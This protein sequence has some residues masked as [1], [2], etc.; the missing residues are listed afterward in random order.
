M[1]S[2]MMN[3]IV[4]WSASKKCFFQF[5]NR[6]FSSIWIELIDAKSKDLSTR[7]KQVRIL[8][9]EAIWLLALDFRGI[10]EPEKTLNK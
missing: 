1:I 9:M 3:D 4:P 10:D 2:D 7:V 5:V 8:F 6:N